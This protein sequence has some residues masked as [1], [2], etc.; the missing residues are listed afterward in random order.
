MV[1]ELFVGVEM[2]STAEAE[3]SIPEGHHHEGKSQ[4]ASRKKELSYSLN[5]AENRAIL[6]KPQAECQ[7]I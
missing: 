6:K 3:R 1:G 5:S 7:E 2:R 4:R